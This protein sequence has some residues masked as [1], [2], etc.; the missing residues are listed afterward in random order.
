VIDNQKF[1]EPHLEASPDHPLQFTEEIVQPW[2]TSDGEQMVEPETKEFRP[3]PLLD[4]L[5]I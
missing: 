2:T 3:C 5:C 4:P 1:H